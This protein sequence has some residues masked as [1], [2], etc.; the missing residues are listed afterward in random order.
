MLAKYEMLQSEGMSRTGNPSKL[1]AQNRSHPSLGVSP[2]A[3]RAA[4]KYTFARAEH[5]NRHNVHL[6]P[7]AVPHPSLPSSRRFP[8]LQLTPRLTSRAHLLTRRQKD[9][10]RKTKR[11]KDRN[12]EIQT[13]QCLLL[14]PWLIRPSPPAGEEI[15]QQ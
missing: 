15:P 1:T 11:Q 10:Y 9:K 8:P 3:R 4:A 5:G 2:V 13:T 6:C 14:E 12:A 7:A